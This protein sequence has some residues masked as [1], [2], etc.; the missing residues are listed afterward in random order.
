[1]ADKD[2]KGAPEA[3]AAEGRGAA[4]PKE[5]AVAR[6][7]V[8]RKEEADRREAKAKAALDGENLGWIDTTLAIGEISIL[9]DTY[10][11]I[12]SD[13]DPRPYEQREL[14]EDFLKELQRRHLENKRGGFEVRFLIP[15]TLRES[16]HEGVIRKRLREHFA[17]EL[18]ELESGLSQRRARGLRSVA[19]G[20]ALL[21]VEAVMALQLPDSLLLRLVS[22]ILVPA[23]W[24]FAW[25]GMERMVEE[26]YS[27]TAQRVFYEK[28]IK[29]NYLFVAQEPK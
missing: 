12:F 24:F 18:R 27:V 10:D 21:G 7:D 20:L 15:T 29:C 26:P 8:E 4:S 9:L 19:I 23:G 6:R 13:F 22:L 5:Q 16:R 1:M 28:F 2:E 17:H 3:R 11:D 25:T 14:S